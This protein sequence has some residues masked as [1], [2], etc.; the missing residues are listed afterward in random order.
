MEVVT[1]LHAYYDQGNFAVNR[2]GNRI[3]YLA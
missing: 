1:S 3:A 2:A